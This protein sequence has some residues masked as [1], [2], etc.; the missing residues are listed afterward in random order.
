MKKMYLEYLII[1]KKHKKELNKAIK[2]NFI[3]G[4]LWG[5]VPTFIST[6]DRLAIFISLVVYASYLS[7]VL[8]RD[9]YKTRF[10]RHIIFPGMFAIGGSVGYEIAKLIS[11][12]IS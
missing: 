8:N 10:G 2:Q 11:I 5:I 6:G 4:V 12:W 7:V 1:R 3:Y 9:K